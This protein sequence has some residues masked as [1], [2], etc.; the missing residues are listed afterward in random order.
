MIT[1]GSIFGPFGPGLKKY[2]PDR[3]HLSNED[4][5]EAILETKAV[6]HDEHSR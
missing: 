4:W 5:N 6:E 2:S 3:N 1:F